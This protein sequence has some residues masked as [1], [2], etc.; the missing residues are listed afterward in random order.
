MSMTRARLNELRGQS[1]YNRDQYY[2][3][4]AQHPEHTHAAVIMWCMWQDAQKA[5]EAA[6]LEWI[7]QGCMEH[8]HF[9]RG[10]LFIGGK[11]VY[12]F[13]A[14]EYRIDFDK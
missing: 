6:V 3:W 2:E 14:L 13:Q 7:R 9:G 11:E 1:Q 10:T 4:I 5:A 12:Q 8:I